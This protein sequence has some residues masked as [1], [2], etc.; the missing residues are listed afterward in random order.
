M[1]RGS[2]APAVTGGGG[3]CVA[4]I[5]PIFSF[6][7]GIAPKIPTTRGSF[8]RWR[9]PPEFGCRRR[10]KSGSSGVLRAIR[11]NRPGSSWR[12]A[13]SWLAAESWGH[14]AGEWRAFLKPSSPGM[15]PTQKAGWTRA[16]L[17]FGLGLFQGTLLDQNFNVWSGRVERLTDALRNGPQLDRVAR[18]PGVQRRTIGIGVDR[19]TVAIVSGSTIRAIGERHVHVFVQSNGGRTIAW[20]RLAAGDKPLVLTTASAQER[21]APQAAKADAAGNP[22]GAPPGKGTVV[23]HGGGSTAEMYDLF[24]RLTGKVRPTLVH[25]PSA[26]DRYRRMSN[27]ELM[28]SDLAEVWKTDAVGSLRFINA[29]T[30]GRAEEPEFC[31]LL[32]AADA[33]WIMGGDQET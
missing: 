30:P 33:L 22:F 14:R 1:K 10:I 5:M 18:K 12:C 2:V 13:T 9:K 3:S 19:Q 27:E 24:P 16:R 31:G 21:A 4:A 20:H 7:T 23:L 8:P 11:S 32:D 15:P 6:F 26:S 17:A 29:D 25:C 28:A